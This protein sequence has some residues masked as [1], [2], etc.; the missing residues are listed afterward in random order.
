MHGG[1]ALDPRDLIEIVAGRSAITQRVRAIERSAQEIIGFDRPPYATVDMNNPIENL[2]L[3]EGCSYRSIYEG[4]ALELPGKLEAIQK[5]CSLGEQARVMWGVPMK[6]IMADRRVAI[7]PLET[8][9]DSIEVAAVVH[10]SALL[11]SLYVLLEL[12]WDQASPVE[13][14]RPAAASAGGASSDPEDFQSRLL[15]LMALVVL[16]FIRVG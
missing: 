6:M 1:H 12:L 16:F 10:P 9:P 13:D 3:Q 7:V 15:T 5:A 2:K 4:A 14:P 8:A 11:D